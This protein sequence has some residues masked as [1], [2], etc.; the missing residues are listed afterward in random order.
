MFISLLSSSAYAAEPLPDRPYW[1]LELK[2]G[3]FT[4][5]LEN[6]EQ[7]YDK[8]NMPA[9]GGTLAYKVLRQLEVGIGAGSARAAGH[10]YAP[11]HGI[12]SGTVVYQIYPVD[13][14][15][16]ARG[17]ISEDQ[18]LVPYVGGGWTRMYYREKVLD[19]ETVRGSADGY[20][21]RGGLQLLLDG[22]DKDAANS[23]YL[24]YGVYHTY[25]FVEAERTQ[26]K[27]KSSS[28]D[29]GGTAYQI[30]LLFEF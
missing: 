20:H 9:Y 5:A 13:V 14:F 8:K 27:V 3:T 15:I 18:W 17:V 30:G 21:Y 23:L 16:L 6:W 4:P 7:Y 10:A 29:L 19:Q 2:G 26:A 28:L 22:I 24:D 1:S 25:F 12:T 11:I